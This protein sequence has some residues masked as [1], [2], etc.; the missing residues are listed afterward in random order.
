MINTMFIKAMAIK[1]FLMT[2]CIVINIE[3]TKSDQY[4][5][6]VIGAGPSG[7]QMGYYFQKAGRDYNGQNKLKK[8]HTTN[9]TL[10]TQQTERLQHNKQNGNNTTKRTVTTQQTKTVTTQQTER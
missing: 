10:T 5:Y 9:K 2:V 3:S 8:N 4:Q 6:C 7:L 1:T